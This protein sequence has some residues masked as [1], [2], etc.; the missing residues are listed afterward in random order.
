MFY[1]LLL[2]KILVHE[3]NVSVPFYPGPWPKINCGHFDNIYF[4]K[5]PIGRLV[6]YITN[7]SSFSKQYRKHAVIR[8]QVNALVLN[9]FIS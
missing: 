4:L 7:I 9:R 5:M 3:K 6:A 2:N 8:L 1:C